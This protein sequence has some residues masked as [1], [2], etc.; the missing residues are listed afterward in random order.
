[1]TDSTG[2]NPSRNGRRSVPRGEASV[3]HREMQDRKGRGGGSQRRRHVRPPPGGRKRHVRRPRGRWEHLVAH[4]SPNLATAGRHLPRRACRASRVH[5]AP[6][7]ERP[8]RGRSTIGR[9]CGRSPARRGREA[10]VR[11]QAPRPGEST[12]SSGRLPRPEGHGIRFVEP[13]RRGGGRRAGVF[14]GI[15]R[16]RRRFRPDDRFGIVR[17][18]LRAAALRRRA[19]QVRQLPS[20]R[21]DHVQERSRRWRVQTLS[22]SPKG[23]AHRAHRQRMPGRRFRLSFSGTSRVE[24]ESKKEYFARWQQSNKRSTWRCL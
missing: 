6:N 8:R 15:H 18:R 3:S 2:G 4:V 24:P 7:E 13:C 12:S 14:R 16:R 23:L 22:R 19:V 17:A 1:M 10:G 20:V 9:T 21:R 5:P 11:R